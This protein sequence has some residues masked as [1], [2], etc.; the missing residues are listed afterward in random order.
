M[1]ENTVTVVL[2]EPERLP[3]AAIAGLLESEDDLTVVAEASTGEDALRAVERL[4]PAVAVLNTGLTGPT[5][6]RTCTEIKRA[7][8][9]TRVLLHAEATSSQLLLAGVEGG[10]DGFVDGAQGAD[11]LLEGIRTVARGHAVVPP[12]MLA[13]L[14]RQLIERQREVAR[15]HER[16]AELTPREREVLE[17]LGEGCDRHRIAEILTISPETAR[18]HIQN[19]MGKLEVGSRV[20]AAALAAELGK[21]ATPRGQLL[22]SAGGSP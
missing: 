20:E 3:R 7:D 16:L 10:A 22:E 21:A 2:A 17:L 6:I 14:L 1:T 5:G 4:R 18:T 15:A 11:A 8:G 9:G 12:A 13:T 19:L